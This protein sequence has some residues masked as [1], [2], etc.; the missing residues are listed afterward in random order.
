MASPVNQTHP[1]ITTRE[2]LLDDGFTEDEV[3]RLEQIKAAYD[4]DREWC[5]SDL[6]YQ[7]MN[8]LKWRIERGLVELG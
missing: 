6:V 2:M 1:V 5:E 7:R 8:F 3:A 4:P